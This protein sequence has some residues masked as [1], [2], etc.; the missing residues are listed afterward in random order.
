MNLIDGRYRWHRPAHTVSSFD[1]PECSR[2]GRLTPRATRLHGNERYCATCFARE[3]RSRTCTSC[4]K[5]RRFHLDDGSLACLS[6]LRKARTCIRCARPAPRAGGFVAGRPFCG[7]CR[8]H[9]LV[10]R[11]CGL[12]GTHYRRKGFVKLGDAPVRQTCSRCERRLRQLGKAGLT[13]AC[14]V[15]Q[16]PAADRPNKPCLSCAFRTTQMRSTRL[17]SLGIEKLWLRELYLAQSAQFIRGATVPTTPM[18]RRH[19]SFFQRIDRHVTV[20]EQLNAETIRTCMTTVEIR[21]WR[22]PYQ[23]LIDAG[24]AVDDA[25]SNR[26]RAIKENVARSIAATPEI[27]RE[28]HRQFASS[29]NLDLKPLSPRTLKAYFG[30]C[31]RFFFENPDGPELVTQSSVTA[32][33]VLHP[34]DRASL[35]RFVNWL[36]GVHGKELLVPAQTEARSVGTKLKREASFVRTVFDTL[37]SLVPGSSKARHLVCFA[38]SRIYGIPL[39]HLVLLNRAQ[40]TSNADNVSLLWHGAQLKLPSPLSQVVALT[41]SPS[42]KS[43]FVFHGSVNTNP[44]T[45]SSVAYHVAELRKPRSMKSSIR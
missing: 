34:G 29:L 20:R 14:I 38:I 30:A 3:F 36:S 16:R 33:L 42:S 24:F 18:L 4:G 41:A 2:C 22:V 19:L 17:A 15:C 32:Y 1:M 6:C 5:K 43:L 9:F 13:F 27:W 8:P 39:E 31:A 10:E 21:R 26:G 44:T 40:V 35:T 45:T 23:F 12:C 25:L 11:I 28:T 37:P 7:P